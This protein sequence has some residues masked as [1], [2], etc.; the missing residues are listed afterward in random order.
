[1][2]QQ[3]DVHSA[4]VYTM[5]LASAADSEMTSPEVG[6]MAEIIK[7]LPVF[8]EYDLA[9]LSTTAAG[10]AELL[11]DENGIDAALDLI[12][13]ALPEKLRETAY[14]L[15]VDVVAADGT[16]SQEE[17]RLLEMLRHKIGVGRLEAAAIERGAGARFRK[18]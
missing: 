2:S 3:L 6:V 16:A 11:A 14:A 15:A 17:L 4:L 7:L 5:V 12:D 1:M 10:C 8:R 18:L 9:T 13:R